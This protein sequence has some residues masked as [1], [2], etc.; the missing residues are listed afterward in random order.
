MAPSGMRWIVGLDLLELSLGALRFASWL[1][2]SAPAERPSGVHVLTPHPLRKSLANKSEEEFQLWVH[3]LAQEFVDEAGVAEEL[4]G[5]ALVEGESAEEGLLSAL[6]AGRGE[7]L[8]IGRKAA[9][10]DESII[11][12]GRVARRL[13]R[14]MPAPIVVV[15]P[16]LGRELPPGPIVFATDLGPSA[17]SALRFAQELAET[18]GREL[19]LVHAYEVHS[20]L[21]SY[22]S[23]NAWGQATIEATAAAE[24]SLAAYCDEHQLSVRS[25]A[26]R[27][28]TA[29]GVL[30]T[31]AR[32]KACMIVTGSRRLS[33]VDRIFTSSV[34]G[35]LAALASIPVAVVPARPPV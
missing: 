29:H 3:K 10:S 24:S 11:R 25:L 8:I 22:V 23:P 13:L 32:E 19:L 28:P 21:Q 33:L 35:D 12:L 14:Q 7:A 16:D 17:E 2:R 34:G 31:A 27:G 15:P 4:D 5:V 1:R 6:A 30:A 26:V 9:S 18:V 20:A